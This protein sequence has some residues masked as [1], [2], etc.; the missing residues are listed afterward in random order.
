MRLWFLAAWLALVAAAQAAPV[1]HHLV[2]VR[3]IRPPLLEE[4][5][6]ATRGNFTGE[7]LYPFPAAFVHRDVA[8]AL[9]RV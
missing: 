4:I 3:T 2:D 6:Y 9:R 8:E 7:V 5:R 1:E